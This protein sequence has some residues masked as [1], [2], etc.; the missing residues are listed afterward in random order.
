MCIRD[1]YKIENRQLKVGVFNTCVFSN[2]ANE[3]NNNIIKSENISGTSFISKLLD[4]FE[5]GKIEY[6]ETPIHQASN[7]AIFSAILTL[8]SNNK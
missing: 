2:I 1:R 5:L 8:N 3:L 4:L 6:F 7:L